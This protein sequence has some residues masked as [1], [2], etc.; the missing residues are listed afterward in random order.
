[1]GRLRFGLLIALQIGS[2]SENMPNAC[3]AMARNQHV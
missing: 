2:F 1:M 3:A